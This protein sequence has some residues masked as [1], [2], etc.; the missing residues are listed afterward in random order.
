MDV[1]VGQEQ[2]Q[3]RPFLQTILFTILVSPG[4]S[5]LGLKFP[6][7]KLVGFCRAWDVFL[8]DRGGQDFP[9]GTKAPHK[10]NLGPQGA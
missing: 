3:Q 8:R 6:Y 5:C 4:E 10:A 1:P 2:S 7:W 9:I